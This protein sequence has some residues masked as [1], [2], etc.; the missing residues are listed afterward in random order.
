M[1]ADKWNTM[2]TADIYVNSE[3]KYASDSEKKRG[4]AVHW[5]KDWLTS[6][7]NLAEKESHIEIYSVD[8]YISWRNSQPA[9]LLHEMVH[10]Y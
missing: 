7:G 10:A 2:K 3:Y 4:M 6:N 5:S 9:M 1:P 8:D